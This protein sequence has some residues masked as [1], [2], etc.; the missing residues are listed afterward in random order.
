MGSDSRGQFDDVPI[1]YKP[2]ASSRM[3]RPASQFIEAYI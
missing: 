3:S 2:S 1:G